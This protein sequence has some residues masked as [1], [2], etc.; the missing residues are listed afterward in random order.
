M[1]NQ[2]GAITEEQIERVCKAAGNA[3]KLGIFGMECEHQVMHR[4]AGGSKSTGWAKDYL[5]LVSES[6]LNAI[7]REHKLKLKTKLG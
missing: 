1:D 7:S 2:E 4:H 6:V 5:S 3:G